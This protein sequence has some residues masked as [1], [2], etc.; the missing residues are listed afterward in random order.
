MKDNSNERFLVGN[1][2]YNIN[3]IATKIPVEQQEDPTK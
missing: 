3:S 2:P 1:V